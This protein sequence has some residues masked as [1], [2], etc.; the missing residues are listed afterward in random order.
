MADQDANGRQAA[1]NKQ[2][3]D[4]GRRSVFEHIDQ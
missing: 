1:Q 4:L 3:I 2:I